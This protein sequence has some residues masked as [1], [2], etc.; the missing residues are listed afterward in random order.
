[1]LTWGGNVKR[2]ILYF[3]HAGAIKLLPLDG[4]AGMGTGL[5][6]GRNTHPHLNPPLEGEETIVSYSELFCNDLPASRARRWLDH[7]Q[8]NVDIAA[9]RIGIRANLV[10]RM[11]KR[12]SVSLGHERNINLQIDFNVK[13]GGDL[14]DADNGVDLGIGMQSRFLLRA[15]KLHCA[16]ETRRITRSKHFLGI[17]AGR[18]RAA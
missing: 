12:L 7:R 15:D 6:L 17:G 18:A 11:H 14:A 13:T 3:L 2:R 10:R 4:K 5:E 8:A 1:M 16:D 9:R